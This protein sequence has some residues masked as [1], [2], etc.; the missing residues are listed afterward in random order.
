MSAALELAGYT[1]LDPWFLLGLP[2]LVLLVAFRLLRR[3]AALPAASLLPMAALP[4]TLRQRLVHAPLLGLGA[5]GVC[6]CV[7]LA[8][9]VVREVVPL[10]SEGVEILLCVDISSS[11]VLND[12][13]P[14]GRKK[15]IDSARERA[16]EFAAARA[17]DR[18]GL[19]AFARYAELRCP[20]TLDEDALAAFLRT[21]DTVPQN[22]ELDGTAIG[23]A[24]AKCVDVLRQSPAK[25]RVVVLLSDGE[26]T[27]PGPG[28]EGGI[29]PEDG[30]ALAADAGIRVHTIGLGTGTPSPFGG[31]I[32]L[33]FTALKQIAGKTGGRFFK[34]R[35]DQDLAD[36]YAEIDQLEKVPLQDPRYR[37][38]DAFAPPLLG[39]LVLLGLSLLLEFLWLR[40]A[41]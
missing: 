5:A 20:L 1:L 34:A 38:T 41:P 18:V 4:A 10:R 39:G 13:E 32:P 3:R 28:G 2:L 19:L 15:R 26:N 23:T 8:R 27:V 17:G 29:Q 25:S 9:P 33:E 14:S 35:T 21:L 6:L 11:M 24:V 31:T 37:T 40:G 12:M 30:A 7:A 36:V 22:S 16:S